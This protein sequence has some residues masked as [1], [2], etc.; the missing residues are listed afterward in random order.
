MI[1]K[2]DPV[3]STYVELME[4]SNYDV[5]QS[6]L[7][8]MVDNS[9]AIIPVCLGV[10]PSMISK[11][12]VFCQRR[13]RRPFSVNEVEALVH[14]VEMLG[15]ERYLHALDSFSFYFMVSGLWE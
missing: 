15:T 10:T 6:S 7:L 14:A 2:N 12:Q 5:V 13:I 1:S 11:K 9:K 8:E 4:H 3:V